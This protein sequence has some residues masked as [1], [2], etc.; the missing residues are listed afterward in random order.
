LET[1]INQP[2][3]PH[4][5]IVVNAAPISDNPQD[6]NVESATQRLLNDISPLL[7]SVAYFAD[8]AAL[9]RERGR[10]IKRMEDLIHCYY[11]SFTVVLVPQ[12]GFHRRYITQLEQLRKRISSSCDDAHRCK[13][14][15]RM[16]SSADELGMFMQAAFD[17]FT[18]TL[19]MPFNFV[20]ASLKAN[21]IPEN[22]G[23]N[24]LQL[25]ISLYDNNLDISEET[26]FSELSQV[27]SSCAL[28]NCIRYRK[29]TTH[30]M[31]TLFGSEKIY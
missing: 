9:W 17:H 30:Q 11:S 8:L 23:G 13:R 16:L 22:I 31:S 21:P 24:I 28:L 19:E 6:W 7:K 15:A 12:Q 1:S 20:K 27:A 26:L 29:G 25:A 14:N 18:T 5:I 4:A 3:L 2:V 10:R